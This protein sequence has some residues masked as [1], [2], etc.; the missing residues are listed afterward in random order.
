MNGIFHFVLEE[1]DDKKVPTHPLPRPRYLIPTGG[2]TVS[3]SRL[4]VLDLGCSDLR[5]VERGGLCLIH[6][7]GLW[8]LK[9]LALDFVHSAK[10]WLEV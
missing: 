4:R 9:I 8:S 5:N 1:V 3:Q 7:R 6:I 2:G 10:L